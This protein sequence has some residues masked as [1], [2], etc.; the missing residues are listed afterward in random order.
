[1]GATKDWPRHKFWVHICC[2]PTYM[3]LLV[4]DQNFNLTHLQLWILFFLFSL[5]NMHF[6]LYS[7]CLCSLTD[8]PFC[9]CSVKINKVDHVIKNTFLHV[10][11]IKQN[12]FYKKYSYEHYLR[13]GGEETAADTVLLRMTFFLHVTACITCISLLKMCCWYFLNL[14]LWIVSFYT[15]LQMCTKSLVLKCVLFTLPV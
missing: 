4:A 14:F 8:S 9:Q 7:V 2:C 3:S 6:S 5:H 12:Q 13:S 15:N 11:Y 1:M 10:Y